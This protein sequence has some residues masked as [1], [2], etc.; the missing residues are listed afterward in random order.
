MTETRKK[1]IATLKKWAALRSGK[2]RQTK[3]RLRDGST[4]KMCC[5]GVLCDVVDPDGWLEAEHREQIDVPA[6]AISR[7]AALRAD[8]EWFGQCSND[9]TELATLNDEEDATFAEIADVVD[10][11]RYDLESR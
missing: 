3:M 7:Q 10:W 11:M 4:N 1:Q 5:L 2:Y 8:K 9:V 6:K